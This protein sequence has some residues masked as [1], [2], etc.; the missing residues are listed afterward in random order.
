M[1]PSSSGSRAAIAATIALAIGLAGCGSSTPPGTTADPATLAPASSALYAG[2]AINPGGSLRK[3]ALADTQTLTHSHEPFRPL[4]QA[5]SG[6]SPLGHVDYAKEVKPWLGP[7]GGVFA[8]SPAALAS[9]AQALQQSLRSGLSFEALLKAGAASLMS[10]SGSGA[11]LVLDTSDPAKARAFIARLSHQ[12][13]AHQ[14]DYRR[15]SLDVDADGHAEAIV[16]KFAVF[17][18]EAGVKAT[19]DTHLGGPSLKAAT[20][21]ATLASKG[22]SG[23]LVSIYLDPGA[24]AQG[25]AAQGTA[26]QGTAGQGAAGTGATGQGTAGSGA[27]GSGA[28]GQASQAGAILQALPGEP[29][30]ARISIVPSHASV[31][32][33]ADLLSSPRSESKAAASANEA[34]QLVGELPS[35]S[36]LALGSGEGGAR[37]ASDLALLSGAV[38][39]ESKSLLSSFG[40]PSLQRLLSSLASHPQTL[41]RLFAS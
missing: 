15:T 18:N 7:N 35:G 31:T 13:G 3:N 33:D 16:G 4:L 24:A 27:A 20:P 22:P 9:A 23:A 21:Y 12:Q 14:V 10:A 32:V 37:A 6:S 19:I 39:L 38:S 28:A 17:G 26:G 11:A 5:L 40:G 36:W 1:P 29:Q 25:A 8:T 30:Q 2:A 41:Q 34:A